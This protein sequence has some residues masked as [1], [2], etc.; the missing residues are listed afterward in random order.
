MASDSIILMASTSVRLDAL[1]SRRLQATKQ[2]ADTLR[3]YYRTPSGVV[4]MTTPRN[5]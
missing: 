2:G 4:I 1:G 3:P 5:D